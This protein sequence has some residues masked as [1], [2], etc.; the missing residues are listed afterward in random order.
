MLVTGAGG[1]VGGRLV[2]AL[3]EAPGLSVRA[4]VRRPAPWL[5]TDDVVLGDLVADDD[6]ARL[7]CKGCDAV[8]H[9]AGPNEAVDPADASEHVGERPAACNRSTATTYGSGGCAGGDGL[10]SG[11]RSPVSASN[12]SCTSAASVLMVVGSPEPKLYVPDEIDVD[13]QPASMRQTSVIAMKSRHWKPCV[14]SDSWPVVAACR[15]RSLATSV[16]RATV[17]CTGAPTEFVSRTITTSTS[18]A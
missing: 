4:L 12:A 1:Y 17:E 16:H 5:V 14:F 15:H 13:K 3:S 6:V 9:L 2:R 8:V 10:V 7:A 11:G 18:E